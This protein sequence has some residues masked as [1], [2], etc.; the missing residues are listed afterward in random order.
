MKNKRLLALFVVLIVIVVFVVLG[1]TVF[2]IKSIS[3]EFDTSKE[4]VDVL[5]KNEIIEQV[6]KFKGGSVFFL[7]E[8]AVRDAIKNPY[9]YLINIERVFPNL[10]VLHVAEKKEMFAI[11]KGDEYYMLDKDGYVLSV[12]DANKNN[13]ESD[14]PNI[15]VK[16]IDDSEITKAVVGQKIELAD[17]ARLNAI[18]NIGTYFGL[19]EPKPYTDKEVIH[20]ISYLEFEGDR[21]TVQTKHVNAA[22]NAEVDTQKIILAYETD[23]KDKINV[24]WAALMNLLNDATTTGTITV[25]ADADAAGGY[26]ADYSSD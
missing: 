7:S 22:N 15:L 16:N 26:R 25:V 8:R 3:V 11:K 9:A 4:R 18:L 1:S 23:V 21:L 17:G 10:I 12:A 24:A 13:I 20:M 14:Y 5:D 6:D 2:T 19:V